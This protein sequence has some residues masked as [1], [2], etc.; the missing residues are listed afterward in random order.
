[1]NKMPM[2][3]PKWVANNILHTH[4]HSLKH[5]LSIGIL[6]LRLCFEKRFVC[7]FSQHTTT[8]CIY[9]CKTGTEIEKTKKMSIK[10]NRLCVSCCLLI[11]HSYLCHQ[12]IFVTQSIIYTNWITMW[13][14]KR[15]D[16]RNFL[17]QYT[18]RRCRTHN[19]WRTRA[20]TKSMTNERS[21]ALN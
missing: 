12:L 15:H 17:R 2:Y 3:F 7:L 18:H 20:H 9:R 8:I 16:F 6:G 21:F 1:M 14:H 10:S 11:D 13:C 5:R 4:T 19:K